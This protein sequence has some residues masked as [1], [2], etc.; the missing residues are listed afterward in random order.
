MNDINLIT[1][2]AVRSGAGA[3]A[4]T[5]A[6]TQI[7]KNISF[8]NKIPTQLV[9]YIVCLI[10]MECGSVYFYGFDAMN[11]IITIFNAAIVSLGSNGAYVAGTRIMTAVVKTEDDTC[12]S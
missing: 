2:E 6:I 7:L 4:A 10:V 8:I 9:S 12:K 5:V 3:L 1:W 11:M